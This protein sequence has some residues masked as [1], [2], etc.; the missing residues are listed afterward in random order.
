MKTA[1]LSQARCLKVITKVKNGEVNSRALDLDFIAEVDSWKLLVFDANKVPDE[2]SILSGFESGTIIQWENWDR[3]PKSKVDFLGLVESI[4]QY[5]ALCFHRFIEK[6]VRLH[7]HDVALKPISPI[8]EEGLIKPY[9][10]NVLSSNSKAVMKSYLLK[11][12][13][14]WADAGEAYVPTSAFNSVQLFKGFEIQQGI[15][16]YRCDRL[17]TPNGGWLGLLRKGTT[18][19]LARVTINYPNT[20]DSE[21]SL[22]I[23]KTKATA[24]YEFKKK[25]KEFVEIARKGSG[26]K[27][28]DPNRRKPLGQ[29]QE[30][31]I[32]FTQKDS[33]IDA[34][35]YRVNES[36]PIFNELVRKGRIDKKDLNLILDLV[37]DSIPVNEIIRNNEKNPGM[38]DRMAAVIEL[39][40]AQLSMAETLFAA[41]A[42][43]GTKAV[44]LDFLLGIEPFHNHREF[45]IDYL[46]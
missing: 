2:V 3:A 28:I 29:V 1:S 39:T 21:W 43:N 46:K 32:W 6:G 7:C 33:S 22:D 31:N 36:H 37:A 14:N 26:K 13:K 18:S 9:S 4:N 30:K 25:I 41:A 5:L 40:E 38:T 35:R 42:Q 15:Y 45:L 12:P 20:A 27:F 17:L 23:T 8:P 44:A 10:E 24:P 34:Y 19:K 16:I 11:H